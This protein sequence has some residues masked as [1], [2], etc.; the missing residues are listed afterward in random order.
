MCISVFMCS[1]KTSWS[2]QVT[3]ADGEKHNIKFA[4]VV[5][6][7]GAWTGEIGHMAGIGKGTGILGVPI[8][9]EPR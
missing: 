1:P 4:I 6:A 5:V 8:P 2:V 9:I 7:A 3:L